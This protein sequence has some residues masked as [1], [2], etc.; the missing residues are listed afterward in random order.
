[1]FARTFTASKDVSNGTAILA[2][3]ENLN[4]AFDAEPLA[5][6]QQHIPRPFHTRW[7][8]CK[9]CDEKDCPVYPTPLPC[10]LA[11]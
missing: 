11:G 8:Q 4:T 5:I 3:V 9:P 2:F 7:A 1:M 10:L 6:I